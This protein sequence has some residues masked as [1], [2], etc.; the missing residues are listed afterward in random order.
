MKKASSKSTLVNCANGF[1]HYIAF[2]IISIKRYLAQESLPASPALVVVCLLVVGAAGHSDNCLN[3]CS[4]FGLV[5]CPIWTQSVK[6]NH[7]VLHT[8]LRVMRARR[9]VKSIIN[10]TRDLRALVGQR[11]IWTHAREYEHGTSEYKHDAPPLQKHPCYMAF[12]NLWASST[13]QCYFEW[14]ML[15]HKP[16]GK[17]C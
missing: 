17:C 5:L 10:L 4:F 9:N 12:D 6:Q 13:V 8:I 15:R 3:F 16:R 14:W 1:G 2:N 11:R 7:R